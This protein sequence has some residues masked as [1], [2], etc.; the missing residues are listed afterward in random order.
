MG[1]CGKKELGGFGKDREKWLGEGEKV[2]SLQNFD[3]VPGF[4]L[5]SFVPLVDCAAN[6]Q[7]RLEN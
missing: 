2:D 1:K 4:V 6:S 7:L 3:Q 5:L